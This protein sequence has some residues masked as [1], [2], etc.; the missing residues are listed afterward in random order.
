MTRARYREILDRLNWPPQQQE[1]FREARL[2]A[3]LELAALRVPFYQ[4]KLKQ[5]GITLRD[6]KHVR[7][8]TVLPTTT[9]A[10]LET[11]GPSLLVENVAPAPSQACYRPGATPG[12]LCVYCSPEEQ[13]TLEVVLL[14]VIE[15]NGL[16]GHFSSLMI[17]PP[18]QAPSRTGPLARL[19]LLDRFAHRRR[20]FLSVYETTSEHLR[21]ARQ[22]RPELVGA[23]L[24]LLLRMAAETLGGKPLGY[25]P[26]LLLTWGESLRS[27]DR[28]TLQ[29]AFGVNPTDVYQAWEFGPLA[30]EGP[31]H[32]GLRVNFDLAYIEII[33]GDRRA[34]LGETGEVVVTTLCNRTMPLIRY[35]LG[36]LASWKAPEKGAPG[37]PGPTL[38][39]V[40][41]RVGE[42][43]ILPTGQ[44]VAA[45][46]FEECMDQFE[47]VKGYR[48]VQIQPRKVEVQV[49]PDTLFC[50]RT[51]LLIRT[52]CLELFGHQVGVE[53]R[54]VKDLPRF[55]G[56]RRHTVVCN[57]A[58][59]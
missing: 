14:R 51:A 49:V 38:A 18:N 45:R 26:R 24:W 8:L 39:G 30:A 25:T 42:A 3:V 27:A 32:D 36:D 47:N 17:L 10:D 55:E 4:K 19:G 53:V 44:Y 34:G 15:R 28:A 6:V 57:V 13:E 33:R 48:A 23:P 31:E 22:L 9:L 35:R 1:K 5:H 16:T 46:Q 12:S 59:T 40:H 54:P 20:V 37:W 21:W 11:D 52:K 7:D 58:H 41:G 50:D 56:R 2:R 43:V 29:Q